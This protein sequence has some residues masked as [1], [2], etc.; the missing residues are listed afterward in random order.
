M[1]VAIHPLERKGTFSISTPKG[2]F[3]GNVIVSHSS[4][5]TTSEGTQ[6]TDEARGIVRS[7]S[8][9]FAHDQ[10]MILG[11]NGSFLASAK[12]VTFRVQGTL[13]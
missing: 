10:S 2:S 8:G 5:T 1:T 4:F 3:R 13:P 11:I 7:G 6:I 12:Q 9:A